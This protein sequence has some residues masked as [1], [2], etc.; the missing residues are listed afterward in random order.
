VRWFALMTSAYLLASSLSASDSGWT[1]ARNRHFEVYSQAGAANARSLLLWFDRLHTFFERQTGLNLDRHAPV[2]ILVFNSVE[3]YEPVRLRPNSDAY[4]LATDSNNYIVLSSP[5]A[6]T[7]A[8]HEYWHFVEHTEGLHLPVALNEG[9]AEFYSTVQMD[10]DRA[11][12]GAVPS[13][14]FRTLQMHQSWTPLAKLLAMDDRDLPP[15]R[16]TSEMFYSETW[17]LCHMLMLAPGYAPHFR[18]LAGRLSAQVPVQQAMETTYSKSLSTI[19]TDLRE[20]VT[21]LTSVTASIQ[22][23]LS[24]ETE[25]LVAGDADDFSVRSLMAEILRGSGKVDEAEQIYTKL[26]FE[27]PKNAEISAARALLAVRRK[28]LP[29]ARLFW[30]QALDDGIRDA[31]VCYRFAVLGE[32]VGMSDAEIRPALECAIASDPGLD[33]AL[34]KLALIENAAGERKAALDHLRAMREI[35]PRRRYSYWM[36]VSDILNEFDRRDEALAA[37][38]RAKEWAATTEQRNAAEQLAYMAETDLTVRFGRDSNG[39]TRME[40]ARVRHNSTDWNPFVEPGD[41]VRRIEGHLLEIECNEAE[42][43]F[44][45]ESSTGV[46]RISLPDPTRVKMTNA[47]AEFTCGVQNGA[48]VIAVYAET[49]AGAGLL[50]G[51]D[52]R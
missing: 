13:A 39:N 25:P 2:Q 23:S 15:D 20:W 44:V 7:V 45:V 22:I 10:A 16:Q 41:R 36:V 34:F 5:R 1:R 48:S 43:V 32:A 6:Q 52:F 8:A 38:E 9:L 51:M 26:A 46:V 27:A 3:Q 33:D 37:A 17:A 30:Q 24:S 29:G 14:R 21:T 4:Y 47:P 35:A 50:R 42:N 12:I 49:A 11:L 31:R 28:D 40:T 19:A 18:E